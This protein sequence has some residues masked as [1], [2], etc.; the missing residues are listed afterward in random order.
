MIAF[1]L[2]YVL[3]IASAAGATI[4]PGIPG[5]LDTGGNPAGFVANLYQ[6][7]MALAGILAFGA[8]VYGAIQYSL[9][10]GSSSAASDAKDRIF[11]AFLGILLLAGASIIVGTINP[12]LA[13]LT[14][15]GLS[16]VEGQ[17]PVELTVRGG[18]RENLNIAPRSGDLT[19]R[20]GPGGNGKCTAVAA[21]DNPCSPEKLATTCFG[22]LGV[23][24]SASKICNAESA[25]NPINYNRRYTC[26]GGQP[27]VFGLFQ[28]NLKANRLQLA[29][30]GSL[31]CPSAFRKGGGPAGCAV[32]NTALYEQCVGEA[33]KSANSITTACKL[34]EGRNRRWTDWEVVHKGFACYGK[35]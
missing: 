33:K 1:L 30:G 25:A 24:E 2:S 14:L 3:S 15:P 19:E 12:G 17:A 35:V 29:S 10:G 4:S 32:V 18:L 22:S 23:A 26:E 21:K 28:I 27:V 5:N 13:I 34:Y 8:I 16:D 11:Q 9:S 31:N 6:F 7:G 20:P